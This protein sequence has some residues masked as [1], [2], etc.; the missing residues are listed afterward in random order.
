MNNPQVRLTEFFGNVR[1]VVLS[2][3]PALDVHQADASNATLHAA[4]AGEPEAPRA[5]PKIVVRHRRCVESPDRA[6]PG[7]EGKGFFPFSFCCLFVFAVN[8]TL[9]MC[10]RSGVPS[11]LVNV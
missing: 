7:A 3:G 8:W 1:S 5:V 9:G 2:D 11:S 6:E 10:G 4:D